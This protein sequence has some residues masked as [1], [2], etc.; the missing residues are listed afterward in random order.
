VAVALAA[1]GIVIF[2][3]GYR[4][5]NLGF[6]FAST[7]LA[8]NLQ[9]YFKWRTGNMPAHLLHYAFAHSGWM[10]IIVPPMIASVT[11]FFFMRPFHQLLVGGITGITGLYLFIHP[12]SGQLSGLRFIPFAKT[13][14]VSFCW[15]ALFI[16]VCIPPQVFSFLQE[17]W[18]Y[19]LLVFVQVWQSCVLFDL[20][21][22]ETDRKQ[23]V[24]TFANVLTQKQLL[25]LWAG[26][27]AL[28][29]GFSF[30]PHHPCYLYALVLYFF[31]FVL[32]L[33]CLFRPQMNGIWFTFLLDGSLIPMAAGNFL[34]FSYF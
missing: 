30:V 25:L 10:S 11:L 20:R 23:G 2:N 13:L 6:V 5:V 9:R 3:P 21:D 12:K 24:K 8:Y 32:Q 17:T 19:W 33:V 26:I 22:I 7:M 29:I 18:L 16:V 15:T 31:A 14:V 28:V 34:L 27:A 1:P 4:W